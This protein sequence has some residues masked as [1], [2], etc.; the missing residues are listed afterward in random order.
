MFMDSLHNFINKICVIILITYYQLCCF[1]VNM[2]DN[3]YM[4]MNKIIII[5]NI[6]SNEQIITMMT[7]ILLKFCKTILSL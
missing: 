7:I 6:F 3:M 2:I 5:T 4:H 1:Y